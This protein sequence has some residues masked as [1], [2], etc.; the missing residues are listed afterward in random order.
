M[1]DSRI[2][3]SVIVPFLNEEKYI[4]Q[5]LDSLLNQD[6]EP[7]E[8]ELIFIDN[9]STDSSVAIVSKYKKVTLLHEGKSHAYA[10]RPTGGA[11]AS[12]FTRE[13]HQS[14]LGAGPAP[15]A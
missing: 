15:Q 9:N 7:A 10:S 11:K 1:S 3:I 12:A 2:E 5:C 4:E 14:V 6:K 8:F 13:G